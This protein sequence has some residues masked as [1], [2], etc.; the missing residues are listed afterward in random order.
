MEIIKTLMRE[1]R[2]ILQKIDRFTR[3]LEEQSCTKEDIKFHLDYIKVYVDGYHHA[4]EECALYPWMAE[5][6]PE[7][8][9]GPLS[10]MLSDHSK[11]RSSIKSCYSILSKLGDSLSDELYKSLYREVSHFSDHMYAHIQKE[12]NVLY[13]MA[14]KLNHEHGGGDEYCRPI[15]DEIESEMKDDIKIFLRCEK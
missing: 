7:L 12:D 9:H 2:D 10:V 14:K 1:H 6:S 4:K 15:L 5:K 13:K 11:G 8:E 3:Q